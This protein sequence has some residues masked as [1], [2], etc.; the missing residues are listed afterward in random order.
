MFYRS[1]GKVYK[2][3]YSYRSN[4]VAIKDIQVN[5]EI[6]LSV[7][8]E[9]EILQLVYHPN[10]VHMIRGFLID[11]QTVWIVLDYL[12]FTLAKIIDHFSNKNTDFTELQIAYFSRRV[13]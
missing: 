3:N 10:I 11:S 9:V 2:A 7:A 5:E 1:F 13:I 8:N 6:V 12:E 4:P